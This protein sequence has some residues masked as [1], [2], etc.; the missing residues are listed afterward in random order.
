MSVGDYRFIVAFLSAGKVLREEPFEDFARARHALEF[1]AACGGADLS[2][3]P[4]RFRIEP[5]WSGDGPAVA[6]FNAVLD[7]DGRAFS[8][9][10][11]KAYFRNFVARRLLKGDLRPPPE[12]GAG[13]KDEPAIDFAV[14]AYA[15]E[16]RARDDDGIVV[17]GSQRV[18]LSFAS[19]PCAP[20]L[21][22]ARAAGE[23]G[24]P[25]PVFFEQPVIDEAQ[26]R[27]RASPGAEVGGVLIGFASRDPD[28]G[29][30]YVHVT[31]HIDARH[32]VSGQLHLR[33]TA[34]TWSDA[35]LVMERRALG[36]RFVG[37]WHSHHPLPLTKCKLCD[38]PEQ[39]ECG[40]N[41]VFFSVDDVD[42]FET[43]FDAA[44]F[45]IALVT[46]KNPRGQEKSG[47]FGWSDQG[48]VVERGY[49][50]LEPEVQ[51]AP[52]AEGK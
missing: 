27:S 7:V 9:R 30:P 10:F 5:D 16:A 41:S 22:R 24:L 34:E 47:L 33:F 36:E 3:D 37:F 43:V 44:A 1:E 52:H 19:I 31:A 4:V 15:P 13:R 23:A 50:V 2:A 6:G 8:R 49:Y 38:L 32:T 48:T 28:S 18:P 21:A 45:S 11:G 14:N 29:R 17:V 20:L 46:G 39:L 42:F 25:F 51:E 12:E 35:R 26:G 40:N